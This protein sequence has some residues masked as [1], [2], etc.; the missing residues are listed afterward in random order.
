MILLLVYRI[1]YV[2]KAYLDDLVVDKAF[3][4]KGLG[5]KLIEYV[6]AYAKSHGAAYLDFT[7]KP[8]RAEGN[9]LYKELGFTLRETNV[10]RKIFDYGNTK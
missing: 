7:S 2:R 5:T 9:R 10:Y 1:P 6:I 8:E 3:R 4:G